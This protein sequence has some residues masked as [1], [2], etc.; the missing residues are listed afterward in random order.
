[1]ESK[2][3]EDLLDNRIINTIGRDKD[4]NP[5][6]YLLNAPEGTLAPYIEYQI[7]TDEGILFSEGEE[8]ITSHE[9][10]VDIFSKG[11]YENIRNA[12]K[13]VLKDKGYYR[14]ICG[15]MYEKDTKL[16]HYLLRYTK[17]DY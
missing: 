13:E 17:G 12:I 1:M 8:Q 6:I 7:V 16:F 11:S 9:I 4:G 2:I 3:R 15:S 10:Q 14:G 5:K